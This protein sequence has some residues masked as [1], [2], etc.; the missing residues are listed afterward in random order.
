MSSTIWWC[1]K[2][3]NGNI[4][5]IGGAVWRTRLKIRK[6]RPIW[7]RAALLAIAELLVDVAVRGVVKLGR[8]AALLSSKYFYAGTAF[9]QTCVA[10]AGTLILECFCKHRPTG[11][12]ELSRKQICR[13]QK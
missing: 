4:A 11:L 3:L 13:C 7:R 2:L 9:P 5:R 1:I 10:L 6:I 8:V 12:W